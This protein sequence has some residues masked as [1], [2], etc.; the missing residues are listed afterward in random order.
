MERYIQQLADLTW[1]PHK[2][3]GFTFILSVV[4]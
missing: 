4:H 1:G 2:Q 3:H